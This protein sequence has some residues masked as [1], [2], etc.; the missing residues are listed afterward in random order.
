MPAKRILI[1]FA[2]ALSI[3]LAFRVRSPSG[4]HSQLRHPRCALLT[5]WRLGIVQQRL[6]ARLDHDNL[7]FQRAQHAL[8]IEPLL[9]NLSDPSLRPPNRCQPS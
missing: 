4:R 6:Q 1:V 5:L 3:P 7:V 8:Q 2:R 9:Y